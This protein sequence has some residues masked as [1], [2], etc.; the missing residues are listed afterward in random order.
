MI[1]R[2]YNFEVDS[3]YITLISF[4]SV[5]LSA[6][7]FIN[8]SYPAVLNPTLGFALAFAILFDNKAYF[9]IFFG[10]IIGWLV[11]FTFGLQLSIMS[12]LLLSVASTTIII[13]Q[14]QIARKI[15]VYFEL[16]ALLHKITMKLVLKNVLLLLFISL[17]GAFAIALFYVGVDGLSNKFIMN[18]LYAFV[19][20]FF[21][22]ILFTL[23]S[24]WAYVERKTSPMVYSKEMRIYMA[25]TMI[26]YGL[27]TVLLVSD[28]VL[29]SFETDFYFILIFY[30][31]I[32]LIFSYRLIILFTVSFLLFVGGYV[33][34]RISES[35]Q[36][37]FMM[38]YLFFATIGTL[39]SMVIKYI[40]SLKRE[41]IHE[42]ARK[43]KT[44]DRLI[45]D[46]YEL[47]TFSSA[48]IETPSNKDYMMHIKKT[49]D[50]AMRLVHDA[51]S[52]YCYIENEGNIEVVSSPL[53]DAKKIP[54]L[55]DA[56]V[57]FGNETSS[58]AVYDDILATLKSEYGKNYGLMMDI[59]YPVK[60]R[61][62]L[63]F[64]YKKHDTFVAVIDKFSVNGGFTSEQTA[65]LKQFVSLVNILFTRSYYQAHNLSLKDEIVLQFVRSLDLFDP[66]TKGHSEDVAYFVSA[67]T[68]ELALPDDERQNYYWAGILHDV[69]K[70]GV[71]SDILNKPGKLTDEEYE[72]VKEH[73]NYGYDVLE[74]SENLQMIA[75]FVKHHHEW[76]NGKGYPDGLKKHDIPLGSQIIAVSDMIS[77]MATKRS[78]RDI[79]TKGHIVKELKAYKGIQFAPKIVDIAL[80]LIEDHDI[81]HKRYPDVF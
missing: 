55:Y 59:A 78:Y 6:F 61:A 73:A 7:F 81:L 30:L 66:Y 24:V 36:F 80:M 4:F 16:D 62:M 71:P 13:V 56:H 37:Y 49:L 20:N 43:N 60:S 28:H 21:G 52:G 31:I 50:I 27:V 19:G 70:V 72:I 41:Q 69:G 26:V 35:M 48:F 12:T 3:M 8:P 75:T 58:V 47:L 2:Y 79:Q 1:N 46:I 39:L 25:L 23:P 40:L 76:W 68:E 14:V 29:L 65:Y 10:S 32:A 42:I 15:S 11:V 67:I 63:K 77:T 22:I 53:Y 74:Q 51:D 45:T 34:T 38:T 44:V 54:Y 5:L 17:L 18:T 64:N 57:I 33:D 9:P